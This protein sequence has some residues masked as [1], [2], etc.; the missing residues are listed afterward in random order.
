MDISGFIV[1]VIKEIVVGSRSEYASLVFQNHL[2]GCWTVLEMLGE[3]ERDEQLLAD[4]QWADVA[5]WG[6]M[7]MSGEEFVASGTRYREA[8]E[9][10]WRVLGLGHRLEEIDWCESRVFESIDDLMWFREAVQ[11]GELSEESNR[12]VQKIV[13]KGHLTY[14]SN[15]HG[16]NDCGSKNIQMALKKRATARKKMGTAMVAANRFKKTRKTTCT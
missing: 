5:K 6:F 4:L 3:N 16:S 15:D 14:G 11:M 8:W 7:D 10:A 12:I 13:Q 9:W 1:E 2:Y